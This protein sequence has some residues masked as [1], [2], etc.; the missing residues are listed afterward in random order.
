VEKLSHVTDNIQSKTEQILALVNGLD[1]GEVVKTDGGKG[2]ETRVFL[3][4]SESNVLIMIYSVLD[5]LDPLLF[6]PHLT[7]PNPLL[8]IITIF[9]IRIRSLNSTF[10]TS[11]KKVKEKIFY[12][13]VTF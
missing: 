1:L 2:G 6:G 4:S 3:F 8:L 10:P 13:I 12:T 9:R 5:L 11:C 7:Y